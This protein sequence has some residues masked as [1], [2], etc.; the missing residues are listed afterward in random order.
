MLTE[1]LTKLK[2]LEKRIENNFCFT[3]EDCRVKRAM[4]H[5]VKFKRSKWLLHELLKEK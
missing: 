4:L 3:L 2:E 5:E 1:T